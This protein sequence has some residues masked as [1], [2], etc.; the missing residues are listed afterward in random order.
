[1]RALRYTEAADLLAGL[2]G[3]LKDVR[4]REGLSLREVAAVSGVSFST[5]CRV[6]RGEGHS[7]ASALA[8]MRWLGSR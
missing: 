5:I 2:P 3:A 1:M 6:E 7:A 8:L 4:Q